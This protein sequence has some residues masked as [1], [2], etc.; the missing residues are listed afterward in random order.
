MGK[1]N[2]NVTYPSELYLL[3][4]FTVL[5]WYTIESNG[6][7]A[8]NIICYLCIDSNESRKNR[9]FAVFFFLYKNRL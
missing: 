3:K 5:L 8:C 1:K 9:V 2:A 4:G 7:S 6:T